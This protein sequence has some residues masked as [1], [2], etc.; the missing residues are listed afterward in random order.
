MPE[1]ID[2]DCP[3]CGETNT[4]LTYQFTHCAKCGRVVMVSGEDGDFFDEGYSVE[5]EPALDEAG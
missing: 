4:D 1:L 5:V 2:W 3:Q